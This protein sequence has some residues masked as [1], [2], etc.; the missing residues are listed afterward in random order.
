[1]IILEMIH[2][3][4]AAKI[5]RKHQQFTLPT[6]PHI[7]ATKTVYIHISVTPTPSTIQHTELAKLTATAVN[8]KI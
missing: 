1:M 4:Y 7:V 3:E 5:V 8:I 6:F 2:K